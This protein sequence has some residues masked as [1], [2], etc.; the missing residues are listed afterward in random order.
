M[1]KKMIAIAGCAAGMV[2]ALAGC[3]AGMVNSNLTMYDDG[4]GTKTFTVTILDDSS[5]IPG[6]EENDNPSQVGNN[7]PY[8]LVW[9]DELATKVKSYSALEDVEVKTEK[10]GKDTVLTFSYSFNSIAEYNSKTKTLAKNKS[11]EIMDATYTANGNGT[12]TLREYVDNTPI[13]IENIFESLYNDPTA[14]DK[15][16]GG[17]L[18]LDTQ[19]G[20]KKIY[21]VLSVTITVG[22]QSKTV[23]IFEYDNSGTGTGTELRGSYGNPCKEGRRYDPFRSRKETQRRADRRAFRRR[24]RCDRR[25]GCGSTR[26]HQKEKGLIEHKRKDA[27]ITRLF[28]FAEK[29]RPK[30]T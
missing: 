10:Q 13:S 27:L 23:K 29:T 21:D 17:N 1:K 5:I 6:T 12:Y 24:R 14:F 8:L 19:G 30:N 20:F 2:L 4:S 25:S 22:D 11:S 15:T 3:Q 26:T 18:D 9:G 7:T 28:C 16:G